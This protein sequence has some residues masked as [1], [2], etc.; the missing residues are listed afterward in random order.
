[1]R[2]VAIALGVA[3]F[4]HGVGFE[5]YQAAAIEGYLAVAASVLALRPGW[6]GQTWR[7]AYTDAKR[8][9]TERIDLP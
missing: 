2:L 7:E 3:S 5:D 6:F 8:E 9:N 4:V 1:M